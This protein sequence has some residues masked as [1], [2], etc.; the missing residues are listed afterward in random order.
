[1]IRGAVRRAGPPAGAAAAISEPRIPGSVQIIAPPPGMRRKTKRRRIRATFIM[2]LS[3][4]LD[5][6]EPIAGEDDLIHLPLAPS[7]RT[8]VPVSGTPWPEPVMR[9]PW[10]PG[11]TKAA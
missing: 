10:L 1:M 6:T 5:A 8:G 4:H 11:I 9:D 2:P 7:M 3:Y